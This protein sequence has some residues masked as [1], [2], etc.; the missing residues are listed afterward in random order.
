MDERVCG[1]CVLD[2]RFLLLYYDFVFFRVKQN[3]K[4]SC[5]ALGVEKQL[6]AFQILLLQIHA[7]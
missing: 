7:R 5:W 1:A 6:L 4:A 2:S 3:I